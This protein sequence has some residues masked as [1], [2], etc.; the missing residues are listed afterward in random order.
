MERIFQAEGA[1]R[2]K[3]LLGIFETEPGPLGGWNDVLKGDGMRKKIGP[4][5]VGFSR[6]L[7]DFGF[8]SE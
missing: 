1:L 7:K 2:G 5:L 4:N 3:S 8:Y 6:S